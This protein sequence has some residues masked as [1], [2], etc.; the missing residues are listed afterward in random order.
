MHDQRHRYPSGTAR[1]NI[2]LSSPTLRKL[3]LPCITTR[4][5]YSRNHLNKK[6]TQK[7]NQRRL[8]TGITRENNVSES[9]QQF[10]V[11]P[12]TY[13]TISTNPVT[14]NSNHSKRNNDNHSHEQHQHCEI[15]FQTEKN[16]EEKHNETSVV[17]IE[18]KPTSSE[19]LES[20]LLLS[21][22]TTNELTRLHDDDDVVSMDLCLN[23]R[24]YR[25]YRK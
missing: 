17:K 21:S 2:K 13:N 7:S 15:S 18:T 9:I 4:Q 11:V 10:E 8:I 23:T 3:C 20:E 12:R 25:N 19:V 1:N 22:L 16:R 5:R 24:K 6:Q 14:F